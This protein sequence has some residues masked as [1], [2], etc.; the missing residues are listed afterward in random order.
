MKNLFGLFFAA[1]VCIAVC[2]APADAQGDVK[3]TLEG[4]PVTGWNKVYGDPAADLRFVGFFNMGVAGVF[5]PDGPA[6]P[7]DG[8]TSPDALLASY[9]DPVVYSAFFGIPNAEDTPNQNIPYADYPQ[10]RTHDGQMGSLPQLSENPDWFGKSNGA[11]TRGLTVGDWLQISGSLKLMCLPDQR[12]FYHLKVRDAIP[13]GLYTLWGFYFDQET[14]QIMPDYAFGGTS[15]NAYVADMDGSIEATRALN[16]C[17]QRISP[18]ERYIPIASFLT[19]HPD[20]RVNAAVG[21]TVG[22]PPFIGPGMTATPQIMFPMPR[23]AF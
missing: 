13:G 9:A 10:I 20:G 1:V 16:T 22:V 6:L 7:V 15:A 2:P 18:D 12:P 23:D 11:E 14:G 8:T 17:L 4:V 19:F 3:L 5:N 21:H